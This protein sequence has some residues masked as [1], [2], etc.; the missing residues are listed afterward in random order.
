MAKAANED[1]S[2]ETFIVGEIVE[3]V[4]TDGFIWNVKV[5]DVKSHGVIVDS[6]YGKTALFAPNSED[7]SKHTLLVGDMEMGE[8]IRHSKKPLPDY[9]PE[10]FKVGEIVEWVE[11]DGTI[12]DVEVLE[13]TNFGVVVSYSWDKALFAPSAVN[14]DKY[15]RWV[16]GVEQADFIRHSENPSSQAKKKFKWPFS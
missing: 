9:T 6:G 11:P 14:K 16:H 12:W 10:T 13:I 1:K 8:Y 15:A 3:W 4:E 7:K 2:P 5:L